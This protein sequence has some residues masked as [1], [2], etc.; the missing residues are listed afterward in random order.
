M[1]QLVVGE[2]TQCIKS[3]R[4]TLRKCGLVPGVDYYEVNRFDVRKSALFKER[5]D[6]Y[7]MVT[8]VLYNRDTEQYIPLKNI[9][10]TQEVRNDIIKLAKVNVDAK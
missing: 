6:L 1:I 3:A 2:C 4:I 5:P 10:L 7:V 8:A 9:Q